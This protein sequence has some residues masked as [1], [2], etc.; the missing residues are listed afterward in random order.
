MAVQPVISII[1]RANVG[2]STLY[3]RLTRSRDAIVDD[4]P[5]VT[6][7][8]LVGRG[9]VG[10]RACWIIDTGG[11]ERGAAS[12]LEDGVLQQF[13]IAVEESDAI[14]LV[15]DG[16]EGLSTGDVE[17]VEQL[18]G[19]E[20]PVYIAVNK[21]E[22]MEEG[23]AAAE[24]YS[25]GIA[26]T[27]FE[28]S[29]T[30][31]SGLHEMMESILPESEPGVAEDTAAEADSPRVAIFGKP[32]AGKST[33]VNKLVGQDRMIVS[34]VAGTTRDSVGTHF[35]SGG[36]D[37]YLIDTPGVRRRAR[38][39]EK[40]E[41]LSIVK[42]LQTMEHAHVIILVIDAR[43]GITDQ[44]AR[45]AGLIREA[46][47]SMVL[48]VNKWDRLEAHRKTRVRR[49]L[50]T[51]LPFLDTVPVLFISALYG[52]GVDLIMPAVQRVY[53]S[54]MANLGTARL[55]SVL[56]RA[57]EAQP[58]PRVGQQQIK[59]KYAHQGG[60]NPPTVVIHGN[61]LNKVPESYKR[62]LA[63]R[64]SREFGLTGTRVDLWFKT[65]SNPYAR[66]SSRVRS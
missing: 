8:R 42:A 24:F 4:Y 28:I 56:R 52:S 53:E 14:I 23:M 58:P 66:G 37:Y 46:G 61:L 19:Y 16:R 63:S 29:A 54:A 39:S 13:Q 35:T 60:K 12:A 51:E 40:L 22:G 38:V 49:G 30:H 48:V 57:V 55:N 65:S 7:D 5:G 27:L 1:G 43:I 62:Y 3:N 20:I 34:N 31:G 41:R 21:C 10:N 26:E 15:V 44:D 45:L 6:R 33:L 2:K 50:E 47:R 64:I 59:L 9:V 32:N 25:L 17:I 11:Y 36:R 18:R